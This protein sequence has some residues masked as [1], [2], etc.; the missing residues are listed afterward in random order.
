MTG[1]SYHRARSLEDAASRGAEP[2]ALFLAG[3]TEVSNWLRDGLAD[4]A[5]LVDLAALNLAGIEREDGSIRI[6]AG[7]RLAA[8]AAHPLIRIAAPALAQAID[9]SA[10]AAI[11]SRS[12]AGHAAGDTR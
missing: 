3:G 7:S 6:G 5:Q 2:G 4:P 1:P 12:P 10:S 8:I 11:R 9:Q